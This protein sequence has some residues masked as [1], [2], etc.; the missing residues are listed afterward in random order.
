[1]Q[2]AVILDDAPGSGLSFSGNWQYET[3][4]QPAYAGTLTSSEEKG[5]SAAFTVVGSQFTWFTRMCAECGE[6]EISIDNREEATV[7][8]YSADDNFGVGI[9]TTSL[10]D[11]GP[12]KILITVLGKH[13]GPR[14]HGTRV[15]ID[16]V[17]IAK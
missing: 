2:P 11:P 16:V 9:Y 3:N 6:A 13:A 7:D 15:Y 4:L 14:G 10:S 12:H 5:A 17:R 1:M 8:T